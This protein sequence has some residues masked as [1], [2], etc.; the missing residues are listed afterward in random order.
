MGAKEAIMPIIDPTKDYKD[1]GP[2]DDNVPPGQYAAAVS[3]IA[4]KPG[5]KGP[6]YNVGLKIE[7]GKYKG[8]MV[9][10][11]MSTSAAKFCVRKLASFARACA[12]MHK[13]D[14][15]EDEPMF[16]K[17]VKGALLQI[18]VEC[19]QDDN[20]EERARVVRFDPIDRYVPEK[21][22]EP[23]GDE[24]IPDPHRDAFDSDDDIFDAEEVPF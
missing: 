14:P 10:E 7:S 4:M 24:N 18:E 9:W 6:Y 13:F 19:E 3:Y 15:V 23:D 17:G 16:R 2:V 21:K 20:G 12:F 22:E 5:P 8:C 11:I 1:S